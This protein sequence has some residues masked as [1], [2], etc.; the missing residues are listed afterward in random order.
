MPRSSSRT[1]TRNNNNGHD[2]ELIT[3]LDLAL[4]ASRD[5]IAADHLCLLNKYLYSVYR[6]DIKRLMVMMPPRHGKS[7]LTSLYFPA[8]YLSKKPDKRLILTSYE[9]DF[10]S[11]WGGKTRDLITAQYERLGVRVAPDSSAKNEWNIYGHKGGMSTAGVGGAITGKGAD[12]FIIDDPVKNSE[13]AHSPTYR[14][15]TYDWF[16]STA[17]TRLEPDGAMIIIQ[18]RWNKE[19]LCGTIIKESPDDW[20]ILSLPA[21]SKP[22]DLLGREPGKPL[23]PD[24]FGLKELEIIKEKIGSYWFAA[25]YQQD[26]VD[27]N[28]ALFKNEFIHYCNYSGGVFDLEGKL[29]IVEDCTIFQTCDPA[30]STK[31]TADYFVLCTWAITPDMDLIL[32]DVI[33]QRLTGPKQVQLFKQAYHTWKPIAQFV[34]KAGVGET[35]I[36]F[37]LDE[38]LPIKPVSP[39][40]TDK[41]TRAIPAAARMEAGKVFI[42]AASKKTWGPEFIDEILTFPLGAHDDQVD[43]VSYAVSVLALVKK[44][45]IQMDYSK[46]SKSVSRGCTPFEYKNTKIR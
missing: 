31:T 6:G 37:L 45:K 34:E 8:W 42:I 44:L 11:S 13:Q 4:V 39:G 18:T 23:F 30:A 27:D 21:I 15:K 24:R 12:I 36:Q 16:Q 10:A 19:D 14:K 40:V 43:N 25:L 20:T 38:G 29:V 5:F 41:V 2:G 28:T 33:R 9:A 46:L 7:S 1:T 32:L 26:P 17:Y 22:N 3:P 35:L